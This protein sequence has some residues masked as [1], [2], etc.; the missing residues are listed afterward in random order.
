MLNSV[1]NN[2]L[3]DREFRVVW[4]Q[5]LAAPTIIVVCGPRRMSAAM[6]TTYDTDMFEPLAIGNWILKADVSDDSRTRTRSGMT[7]VNV[8]RDTSTLNVSAPSAMTPRMYQRPR[9]G[10]SR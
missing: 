6:S 1:R 3:P 5:P 7:G 9:G 4:L 8:A 10:R 2:G